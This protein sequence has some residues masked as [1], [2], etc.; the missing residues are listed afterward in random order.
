MT[1]QEI[2]SYLLRQGIELWIE[3][4]RLRYR[5][6]KRTLPP[7]LVALLKQ[8]KVELQVLLRERKRNSNEPFPLSYT[9]RAFW[10]L[11]EMNPASPAYIGSL[12]VRLL[13]PVSTP[14]LRRAFEQLCMRHPS[15]RTSLVLQ[16]GVPWQQVDAAPACSLVITDATTW[17]DAVLRERVQA[18]AHRP[19]DLLHEAA[20]RLHLYQR[21]ISESVLLLCMHHIH[22]DGW[23]LG[24]LIRDF[25]ALY[26]S[27][28]SGQPA[29]LSPLSAGYSD[30]VAW[31]Q[32]LL[33]APEGERQIMYWVDELVGAPQLLDLPTD[34]PRP[35]TR[36]ESGARLQRVVDPKLSQRVKTLAAKEGT[37][38]NI[39]LLS[40]FATFLHR[41]SGQEEFMIGSPYHG[42]NEQRWENVL[43][44]FINSLALRM[45]FSDGLTFRALLQ[46]VRLRLH[47]ALAH[48]DYPFPLVVERLRPQRDPSRTPL[49]QVMFGYENFQGADL[50][51]ST[52]A[53][54]TQSSDLDAVF[55]VPLTPWELSQQEG[56][57]DLSMVATEANGALCYSLSYSTDLFER[58]TIEQMASHFERLLLA[59]AE[60]PEQMIAALP[61]LSEAER[62]QVLIDWNPQPLPVAEADTFPNKFHQQV[63]R[64]PDAP[65][66]SYL[67]ETLSYRQLSQQAAQLAH[68]LRELGVGPEVFVGVCLDRAPRLLVALVGTWLAGGAYVPLDPLLPKERLEFMLQDCAA[69]VVL[70]ERRYAERLKRPGATLLFLDEEELLSFSV[71]PPPVEL[72]ASHLAYCIYTSGS[73]GRPRGVLVEQGSMIHLAQT[74]RA[75]L[76]SDDTPALRVSLNASLVF[77]GSVMQILLLLAGDCLHLLPDAV[78]VDAAA[79]VAYT[80]TQRLDLLDCTPTMLTELLAHGLL[81]DPDTAPGWLW[82]GGEAIPEPLWEALRAA[83]RTSSVNLYG[84]TECTVVSTLSEV[85]K[86]PLRPVIGRPFGHVRAYILD[87]QRNLL[88]VGVPGELYLSG[89]GVA[90][91]YL[92]QAKLTAKKFLADPFSAGERM[93]QSGDRARWLPDGNIEYLGRLDF[94]VKLRGYRIELGEIEVVLR[95][96]PGVQDCVVVLQEHQPGDKRLVAYL[97]AGAQGALSRAELA[98]KLRERLAE[99]MVPAVFVTLPA[100]PRTPTG[101]LDRQ[102]LPAPTFERSVDDSQAPRTPVEQALADIFAQLLHLERVG[103]HENFFSLGGHSLLATQAVSRVRR[104]L[105]V[106]LSVAALFAAPTVAGL[107]VAVAGLTGTAPTQGMPLV[108]LLPRDAPLPLSFA[109]QRLWFLEQLEPGLPLYNVPSALRL[110]GPLDRECLRLALQGIVSR[111]EA[112]RTTFSSGEPEPVQVIHPP[113][114][115]WPLPLLDLC[116]LPDSAREAELIRVAEQEARLPFSLERG[117]LL[118]TTLVRVAEQDHVL[119]L[120]LHHIISDGWSLGVLFRELSALYTALHEHRPESLPELRA[121]VADIGAWQRQLLQGE[122]LQQ[123]LSYWKQQLAGCPPLQLPTDHPR[124]PVFSHR[125]RILT[126]SLDAGLGLALKTLA[127]S[128]QVTVFMTLLG[129]FAVLL[130]RYSQQTDIAVGSPI[131]SRTC[132]EMEPLIGCFVN[133]LVLRTSLADSPT[134]VELL[135]RVRKTCLDAYS[136]QQLPFERLVD[137]LQVTRDR[138]RNP[139]FQVM[140]VLQN[141][142]S[143]ELRLPDLHSSYLFVHQQTAKFDLTLS[144]EEQPDGS[145]AGAFEYATDLFEPET[146]AR[147]AG[148]YAQLLQEVVAHADRPVAELELL[149][150][151][152]RQLLLQ[153]WN[154]TCVELALQ[155]GLAA[156]FQAQV[157][158]SPDAAAVAFA[159]ERWTYRE[160]NERA[161][162]LAHHLRTQGVGPDV[163]VGLAVERSAELVVSLLGIL[164]AGGAY[165]PLDPEHPSDRIA[166][167]LAEGR[168]AALV[169]QRTLADRFAATGVPLTLID[170]PAL[171]A[172][173]PVDNPVT[174]STPDHLAYTLFTSGSTGRPKGVCITQGAV[175]N[176]MHSLR[177]RAFIDP[178][179][180]VAWVAPVVFDASVQ[181]IFGALLYGHC[182]YV[183]SQSTRRDGR[184]LLALLREQSIALCDCTPSLLSLLIE[185]GLP[186]AKD[187]GLRTLL[188]GGEELPVSLAAALYAPGGQ[189]QPTLINVY[190]PTECC[191]DATA[192]EARPGSLAPRWK[193]VPIGR[194]L[195]NTQVYILDPRLQPVPI[196]VPGQLYIGGLGLARGYL[197]RPEL[198]RDRFIPNPF[199]TQPGARLYQTGD[200]G[201][202][203]PD[204]NIEFL[205]RIDHQVK[206]RGFRIELGE[207]E[208]VLS[209]HPAVRACVVLVRED[210][211]GDKR[212][213]AYVVS[214]ADR[215]PSSA[216]LRAHLAAQLPDYMLPAA[217]VFLEALPQTPNG[218]LDRRALPPPSY[219][220]GPESFVA[221]RTPVEQTLVEIFAQLLQKDRIGIHD[222]FFSLGG[223]SL[224][225]VRLFA[226]LARRT[227]QTLPLSTLFQHPTV[228]GLAAVLKDRAPA[229]PHQTVLPLQ[230]EGSRPP[231]FCIHPVGGNVLC[232][233]ELARALGPGQPVYGVQ[234]TPS[235][236]DDTAP[237]ETLEAVAS[238]YVSALR[239]VQPAGPYQLLGW[240][241][242]GVLAFEMARQLQDAGQRVALL[243]LLDS[244]APGPQR[245]E[246]QAAQSE[247]AMLRWFLSDLTRQRDAATAAALPSEGLT[248][249]RAALSLL[250]DRGLLPSDTD[251]AQ[252]AALYSLFRRNLRLILDY[253]PGP[254]GG[255]VLLLRA[256]SAGSAAPDPGWQR[257]CSGPLELGELPGDHYTILSPPGVGAVARHL[258]TRLLGTGPA[259]RA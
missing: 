117:P 152:E 242:G 20:T 252:L 209:A 211:P 19:F 222:N 33:I 39:L 234:A 147:L 235:A 121:Q 41:Y 214:Q 238:R 73:T 249:L 85:E 213:I 119:L 153:D 44:C 52:L 114:S 129:S 24:I 102:A 48:A 101:K 77:D 99:Y 149:S 215:Q 66:I 96:Q 131:A 94:Q 156:L 197:N 257:L 226:Q 194:P 109:Q 90:R 247:A 104:A 232:Y 175:L 199:S 37:T 203:L 160:L 27:Q 126:F 136:H 36:N 154:A 116:A 83:K 246:L 135:G 138:S 55:G 188:C 71:V 80:R 51:L 219:E 128:Q 250:S 111:H 113:P 91:G 45:R 38:L 122:C 92:N 31:Q 97:V 32:H 49:F 93:Y 144:M 241:L 233:V 251:E 87:K 227:G 25:G 137:E 220:R 1:A 9:Q 204:G 228:A 223:H 230:P 189:A 143:G 110:R 180:R 15:L 243:A 170:D 255:P 100:F 183:V 82:V 172:A 105:G 155:P 103:V 47:A 195:A 60:D 140:F 26:R 225:A 150:S 50:L 240:S 231:L 202:F 164:K 23:S 28:I 186:S 145:L 229:Q 108:A 244:F 151:R 196:G 46:E 212:L 118:R 258:S 177:Q 161:N 142:P 178:P 200:L 134:F 171:L 42:R 10:F 29:A 187:L 190:G 78:R 75:A 148:H 34:R 217:F 132:T 216:G 206:L 106:E 16:E 120:T 53:G 81:D 6:L 79:L 254:Y 70:T 139:L 205:G 176:L 181:Q 17:S 21:S 11:Y 57:F 146:I 256:A 30:F 13:G 89:P 54:A 162:Q 123:A 133:T 127:Q 237:P 163:L 173:Y 76:R 95:E 218:K 14:A 62:R 191:V 12:A 61:M 157:E 158:R 193:S 236:A 179:Q 18:E 22:M 56:Q 239:Q 112:L 192:F 67:G 3:G 72:K 169:T 207:I 63:A 115:S 174:T 64:T 4:D 69:P 40:V 5:G 184:A 7:P 84:P 65:A 35:K 165:L 166:F 68:R 210:T 208:S 43:G 224:L 245:P 221:P 8:H 248:D 159:D 168:P 253:Q 74:A 130:S 185:A 182:L 125:G 198:T 167:M 124:P 86:G 259:D 98:A 107:A 88:P 141:A 58:R 201:R 2:L 59:V